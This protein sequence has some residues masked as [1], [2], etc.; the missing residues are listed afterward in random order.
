MIACRKM[1]NEA[2]IY[3]ISQEELLMFKILAGTTDEEGQKE[4]HKIQDPTLANLCT[5]TTEWEVMKK[6]NKAVKSTSS[7]IGPCPGS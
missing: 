3:D 2:D 5:S 6:A 7:I 4:L 1:Y